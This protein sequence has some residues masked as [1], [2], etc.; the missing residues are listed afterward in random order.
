VTQGGRSPTGVTSSA[1]A[2]PTDLDE[3]LT[4]SDS[5]REGIARVG[6]PYPVDQIKMLD[7]LRKGLRDDKGKVSSTTPLFVTQ[8]LIRLAFLVTDVQIERHAHHGDEL[9][10]VARD[11]PATMLAE[12][13][14]CAFGP[15]AEGLEEGLPKRAP[16]VIDPAGG[17]IAALGRLHPGRQRRSSCEDVL[18][19][20]DVSVEERPAVCAD[21]ARAADAAGYVDCLAGAA[22]LRGIDSFPWTVFHR[23]VGKL[24]ITLPH[25]IVRTKREHNQMSGEPEPT[26]SVVDLKAAADQAIA[27]CHRDAREAVKAL[28]IARVSRD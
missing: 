3:G 16:D 4:E 13:N 18:R 24:W 28:L 27:T 10:S 5:N 6:D 14:Q 1:T 20:V 12:S 8:L 11:S 17:A 19:R 22:P 2:R 15:A 23:S 26:E 25:S 21:G 7:V 9:Q